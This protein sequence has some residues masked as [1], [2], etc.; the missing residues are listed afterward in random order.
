VKNFFK[1]YL[2]NNI[3]NLTY[4]PHAIRDVKLE[5]MVLREKENPKDISREIWEKTAYEKAKMFIEICKETTEYGKPKY[6]NEKMRDAELRVRWVDEKKDMEIEEE[7]KDDI[8]DDELNREIAEQELYLEQLEEELETNKL[9]GRIFA[10][11][12][13]HKKNFI[14]NE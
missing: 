13:G 2:K 3:E 7:F 5:L 11:L 10:R 9:L 1:F 14:L 4:L 8:K 6:S 12:E